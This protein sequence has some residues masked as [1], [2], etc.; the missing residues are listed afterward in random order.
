[1]TFEGLDQ[2]Q[3]NI[4]FEHHA[5]YYWSLF[6]PPDAL[7]LLNT[8][9]F[10][11]HHLNSSHRLHLPISFSHLTLKH[12]CLMEQKLKGFFPNLVLGFSPT[13]SHSH[14]SPCLEVLD[15]SANLKLSW[16]HNRALHASNS[17]A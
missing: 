6:L 7:E 1:M 17:T 12:S 4:S 9:S 2:L 15:L 5:P 3:L 13:T 8:L 14:G 11:G 10:H 16:V